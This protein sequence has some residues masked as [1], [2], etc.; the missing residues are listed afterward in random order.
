MSGENALS[1][2]GG[3][4]IPQFSRTEIRT[5]VRPNEP[6]EEP[7]E[8]L[9]S[10]AEDPSDTMEAAMEAAVEAVEAEEAA[11]TDSQAFDQDGHVP[12]D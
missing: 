5:W 8:T 2:A 3:S 11:G 4:D 1:L 12:E 9:G 7:D 10:Q 6:H